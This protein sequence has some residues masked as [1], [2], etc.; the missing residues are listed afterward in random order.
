[1]EGAGGIP[2]NRRWEDY[3]RRD[4][5]GLEVGVLKRGQKEEKKKKF[6]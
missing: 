6:F 2:V 5:K 4:R 1:M 3:G